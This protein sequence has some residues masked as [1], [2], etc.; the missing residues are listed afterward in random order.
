MVIGN[1]A[2]ARVD[3]SPT[4]LGINQNPYTPHEWSPGFSSLSVCTSSSQP[5]KVPCLF[6]TRGLECSVYGPIC[7]LPRAI[8]WGVQTPYSS[9]SPS[10]GT[11]PN[12]ILFFL[13]H[14]M[15]YLS[16]SFGCIG[17]LLLVS[18]EN[19]STSRCVF[20]VVLGRGVGVSFTSS[21]STILISLKSD[22]SVFPA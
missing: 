10:R 6:Q 4:C 8:L 15:M 1:T 21:Y 12:P 9:E 11:G 5:A 14:S 18:S 20:D 7:L 3:L 16:Y 19:C 17:V 2:A 13:S 22:S